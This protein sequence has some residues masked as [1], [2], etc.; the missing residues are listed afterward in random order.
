MALLIDQ[1]ESK[2][3]K[4]TVKDENGA[5]IA[6]AD[7]Q[8][9]TVELVL[10]TKV[11]KTYTKTSNGGVLEDTSGIKFEIPTTDSADLAKGTYDLRATIEVNDS[12]FISSPTADTQTEQGF[13]IVL[14]PGETATGDS[15]IVESGTLTFQVIP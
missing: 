3:I 11:K 5:D 6:W 8:E 13:A 4:R 9:F 7:I 10:G 2:L 15:S 14:L 12:R 1:G